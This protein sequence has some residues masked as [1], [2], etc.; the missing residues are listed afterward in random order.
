MTSDHR[1]SRL[2]TPSGT[3]SRGA[4]LRGTILPADLRSGAPDQRQLSSTAQRDRND[5]NGS[6]AAMPLIATERPLLRFRRG[7]LPGS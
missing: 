3:L 4:I 1:S 2:C 7:K 5:D 6:S